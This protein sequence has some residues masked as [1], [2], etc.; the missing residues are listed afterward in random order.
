MRILSKWE[1]NARDMA[2]YGFFDRYEIHKKICH[3]FD[4]PTIRFKVDSIGGNIVILIVSQNAVINSP[5]RGEIKSKPYE[6]A[7][8]NGDCFRVQCDLNA[9]TSHS[10]PEHPNP[11]KVPV[12]GHSNILQW[13]VA[14]QS[15]IGC[16]VE[17]LV[18][19]PTEREYLNEK[20]YTIAWHRIHFD[21]IV[22]NNELFNSAV[23]NGLGSSKHCG[24]GLVT[25]F[26]Q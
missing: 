26:R 19:S 1:L 3:I 8:R 13:L 7:V 6:V 4:S 23:M 14:R 10:T 15:K 2:E 24:F 25:V 20:Q 9:I 11:K 18:V 12:V 16:S 17:N 5:D 22:E 21:A